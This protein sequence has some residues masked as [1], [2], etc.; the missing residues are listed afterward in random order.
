MINITYF[1]PCCKIW[2]KKDFTIMELAVTQCPDCG[3]L[4]SLELKHIDWVGEWDIIIPEDWKYGQWDRARLYWV[5]VPLPVLVCRTCKCKVRLRP[6][7]LL[8]GTRLTLEA[9]VFVTFAKEVGG[10]TW[11]ALPDF[12]CAADDKC[13]HST[14]Y[15][16]VHKVGKF[17]NEQVGELARRFCPSQIDPALEILRVTVKGNGFLAP[18]ARFRH[19]WERELSARYLVVGLLPQGRFAPVR[20]GALFYRHVDG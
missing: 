17:F 10:L 18:T 11:R 7:F 2:L 15:I 16:A 14:L 1:A 3:T 20:F 13:A 19:T 4:Y 6:S 5:R 8:Q 12:F 9:V